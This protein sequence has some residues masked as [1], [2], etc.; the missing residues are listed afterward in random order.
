MT[1]SAILEAIVA[2]DAAIL[3]VALMDGD[4]I[5]VAELVGAGA[6]R[7]FP[8]GDLSAAAV[9]FGRAGG[10]L[11]KAASATR[12]G[13]VAETIVVMEAY[14]L[15]FARVQPGMTLVL[16]LEP[17]GNLG[18]ARYLIRGHLLGLREAL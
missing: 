13:A 15:L 7:L 10:E 2:G 17:D 4:G 14:S 5:A 9:E 16:A 3:G 6:G 11:E 8:D 12:A 1:L 18:K